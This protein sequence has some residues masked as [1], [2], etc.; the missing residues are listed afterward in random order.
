[1]SRHDIEL[2]RDVRNRPLEA[3]RRPRPS[4]QPRV[5]APV[6]GCR[7]LQTDPDADA[8]DTEQIDIEAV[9]DPTPWPIGEFEGGELCER[10]C[11]VGHN[12]PVRAH[13][14][15][16]LLPAYLRMDAKELKGEAYNIIEDRCVGRP[17]IL[18]P[19]L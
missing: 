14:R 12:R 2:N 18:I 10:S 7:R 6:F 19:E 5:V 15:S 8:P 16:R 1:M 17:P 4:K 3:A 13:V 9:S 11:Q